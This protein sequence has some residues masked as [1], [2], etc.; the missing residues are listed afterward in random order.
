MQ[1]DTDEEKAAADTKVTELEEQIE[2][3]EL[4]KESATTQA[5][6]LLEAK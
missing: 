1:A 4:V 2:E 3:L 5:A 6:R